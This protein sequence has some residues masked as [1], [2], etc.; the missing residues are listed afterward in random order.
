[1]QPQ[2]RRM[3][4][5]LLASITAFFLW[6]SISTKFL[7]P[8]TQ[9]ADTRPADQ[10][11][12][13]D[14]EKQD[15]EEDADS[16]EQ[17]SPQSPKDKQPKDKKKRQTQEDE[18][19]GDYQ[20]IGGDNPEPVIIGTTDKDGEFPMALK[21]DPRGASVVRADIRGHYKTVDKA[22]PYSVLSPM[23]LPDGNGSEQTIYSFSTPK[24]RFENLGIEVA[25]D[26]CI[27]RRAEQ[28]AIKSVWSVRILDSDD[29][30]LAR[31]IKTYTLEKQPPSAHTY[32]LSFTIAVENLS[33]E[34]LNV[35]L[36]QHGPVGFQKAQMRMEDRYVMAAFW[37][38]N[39]FDV[40]SA[41]RKAV[42][43]T[44]TQLLA[45][46]NDQEN[47]RIAWAAVGNQYFTCIMRPADR[48]GPDDQRRFA[49]VEAFCQMKHEIDQQSQKN[50]KHEE[51]LTFR[52][53][54]VPQ[55]I[56]QNAS[57]ELPFE[58]YI[59]PKSKQAFQQIDEYKAY[60][61]YEVV[62]V[63]FR[64]CS[65]PPLV[66]FMMN[67]LNVF[68]KIPPHNYGL[69]IIV[70]V[71]VVRGLLH[72]LTK[73]SQV[74]MMKMQKQQAKLTPK[75]NQI[76]EKYANDPT[77]KN[78]AVMELYRE[79]GL[80]PAGNVLACLPMMLQMPIWIALWTALSSTIDMRHAPFDGWWIRDLAGPDA[81]YTFSEPVTIPLIGFLLGG[82]IKSFNLLPVLLGVSQLLQA[83]YMPRSAAPK[84][85]SS[86]APDQMDQQ[87]KMMM[88]MSGLFVLL[89]YNAPSGLNLYIMSSNVFA[90]VEQWRI[91]QHLANIDEQ[92]EEEERRKKAALKAGKK[93]WLQ[94]KWDELA[95]E[96]DEAR[97]VTSDRKKNG[98]KRK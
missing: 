68:H 75:I 15:A 83:K 1:M 95:K 6:M 21:I 54:T 67:L 13:E 84:T 52:Y 34:T 58:C 90:I 46:D 81:L 57:L 42:V 51:D 25:L 38:A 55:T 69:A 76:K 36:T 65:I 97:K 93:N 86:D 77:K 79:E 47:Q 8:T 33:A 66:S 62:K 12:Q 85:T 23:I 3:I 19:H 80:N 50:E 14:S 44:K 59:G 48:K 31:V 92:K 64:W 2:T 71:I 60:N 91:R 82:A 56:A 10:S 73:K 9:P 72:P 7:S 87:R 17:K 63:S 4:F 89:L 32:D 24:I 61:Y 43:K 98:K 94:K 96:A 16:I 30:P 20:V 5:A 88:M 22:E 26:D 37:Q 11:V 39:E 70:L 29:Q 78:Q 41:Y 18:D 45:A 53:I 27:W 28:S 49:S 40:D 74:N 35:I